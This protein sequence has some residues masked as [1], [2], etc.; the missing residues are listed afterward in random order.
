MNLH[1][2]HGEDAAET[3]RELIGNYQKD[4]SVQLSVGLERFLRST[5]DGDSF[6]GVCQTSD[7]RLALWCGF[8]VDSELKMIN[9]PFFVLSEELS[10][11]ARGKALILGIGGFLEIVKEYRDYSF[12][13]SATPP[14]S[15]IIRKLIAP[16]FQF[17]GVMKS[18]FVYENRHVD[19]DLFWIPSEDRVFS[20][21][22]EEV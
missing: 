4:Y 8:H 7:L 3:T 17:I 18:Y 1:V 22:R 5:A 13:A 11:I 14:T 9:I 19:A 16:P 12:F 20:V 2:M 6:I 10:P 21:N 15:R